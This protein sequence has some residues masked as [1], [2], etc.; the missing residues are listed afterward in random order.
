MPTPIL[1]ALVALGQCAGGSCP[2]PMM[3][4]APP[5]PPVMIRPEVRA[6]AVQ[7]PAIPAERAWLPGVKDGR[8][9]WVWGWRDGG[10]TCWLPSE[11]AT[12]PPRVPDATT[13]RPP[14]ASQPDRPVVVGALPSFATG[15]VDRTRLASRERYQPRL[16]EGR[17]FVEAVQA[18]SKEVP[19]DASRLRLTVI[20]SDAETA[21]VLAAIQ[22]PGPLH[23]ATKE[24]HVQTYRPDSP[25]VAGLGFAPGSP[26]I[27]VQEPN[28]KVLHRQADFAGGG[29][30]LA[31]AVRKAEALRKPDPQY[32]ASV[33]ADL[34]KPA[35]PLG[36]DL[37]QAAPWAALLVAALF[38]AARRRRA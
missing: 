7:R 3:V 25:Y 4:F 5:P 20:G 15:G 32:D 29:E 13:E 24:M 6:V 22:A 17:R 36:I 23:D 14:T 28:G 2:A 8:T 37:E 10:D 31:V 26:S 34:R 27:Y 11:Q 1:L 30:A 35:S 21:P 33:D 38:W 12:A 18:K 19:D 9:I 16:G